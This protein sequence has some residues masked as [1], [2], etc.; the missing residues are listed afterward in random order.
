[1]PETVQDL[2]RRVAKQLYITDIS[3][4][5][6]AWLM[7]HELS[8][9]TVPHGTSTCHVCVLLG[10]RPGRVQWLRSLRIDACVGLRTGKVCHCS[11]VPRSP[12][13]WRKDSR[14]ERCRGGRRPLRDRRIA[15][16]S[17]PITAPFAVR[18]TIR[19]CGQ[20]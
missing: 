5:Y 18:F 20:V 19:K 15:P 10:R 14:T 6:L 8:D 17:A 11:R 16:A 2:A 1:M 13:M 4:L 12:A 3:D 7:T 9:D